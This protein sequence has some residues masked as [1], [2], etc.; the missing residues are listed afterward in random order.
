MNVVVL[1]IIKLFG[2]LG[3]FL[4]GMHVMSSG[5]ERTAGHKMQEIMEKVTGNLVK[6]VILGAVVAALTQSSSATTVMVVGFVNAGILS[7]TQAVGIIMGANIGTTI[8][9]WILSLNDIPGGVWYLDMIKPT[10]LAPIAL[11]VGAFML[12]FCKDKKKTVIGEFV[13]GL[14]V[15]FIG[16]EY[17]AD[18][19]DVVFAEVPALQNLF[20]S[21]LNP[22]MGVLI[23]AVVT[24]IIQSSAAS[25]G[26]L[27]AIAST[28]ALAFNAAFPIIM[29]QNIGTCIT[30]ILSS[31]GANRNA[32]KTAAMHLYFN[33]I[34][35]IIFM[36]VIYAIQI[37]IG[38]PF[39]DGNIRAT[40]ISIFHSVFNVTTTIMLLPLAKVL[41][42]LANK[43]FPDKDEAQPVSDRFALLDERFFTTPPIAVSNAKRTMVDM[44]SL[45]MENVISCKNMLE[46]R[47]LSLVDGF[48]ENE[49][50]LDTYEIK[51]ADYLTKVSE[52]TLSEEDSIKVSGYFHLV[53]NIERIGD[54]CDNIRQAV[55]NM[56]NKNITF[57]DKGKRELDVLLNAVEGVTSLA[58]EAFEKCDP[59]LSRRIEPFEEVVDAL[60]EKLEKEHM[61]RLKAKECNVEA[62]VLF[63]EVISNAERISDHCSNIGVAILQSQKDCG[64]DNRHDYLKEVHANMPGTYKEDY[65]RFKEM[66]SI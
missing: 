65:E 66:Y 27:Q 46:K 48:K 41:V 8:T 12:L 31:I 57:T 3:M 43:T 35:T 19:M 15:L 45:A 20:A 59:V 11:V 10:T 40:E 4:F 29:G 49:E 24:A 22:F 54:Y 25:V 42:W 37:F 52:L 56:V 63:L 33:L 38:I 5:L 14:G 61:R 7:L 50:L 13:I 21:E 55:E 53:T 39:W 17:M 2:G 32:K 18:S 64:F 47:D 62:G 1:Q 60:Q 6:A 44:C 9:A 23:G 51:L 58:F 28:G 36:V 30:A 26:M 16:M 34:G